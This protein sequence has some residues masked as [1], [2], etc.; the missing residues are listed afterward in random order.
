MPVYASRAWITRNY[1]GLQDKIQLVPIDLWKRP[2]W[3]KEKV[4][5]ENKVPALEHN[6]VVIGDS[7]DVVKYIDNNFEGPSLL[8]NDPAKREFVEEL[9][10]YTDKF[11]GAVYARLRGGGDAWI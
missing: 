3:Y 2:A 7:L 11:V 4:Y 10:A 9:L 8:P 6:N 5:P 1:K